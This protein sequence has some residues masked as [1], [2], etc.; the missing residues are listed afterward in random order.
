MKIEREMKIKARALRHKAD[1]LF[2][3]GQLGRAR[4]ALALAQYLDDSAGDQ[5]RQR[6]VHRYTTAWERAAIAR[7]HK[8][9]VL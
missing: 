7:S 3:H 9:L 4:M 1:E 5:R 2:L 8:I 6:R